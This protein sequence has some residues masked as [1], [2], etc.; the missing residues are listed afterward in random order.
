MTDS[1]TYAWIL[2]SVPESGGRLQD[3]IAMADGINH[4][5]PTHHELQRSLGWLKSRG[6]VLKQG[7]TFLLT[8]RGADLLARARSTN[9]TMMQTWDRVTAELTSLGGEEAPPDDVTVEEE[10]SA[11]DAYRKDFWKRY[12]SLRDGDA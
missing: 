2:L 4:A 8:E 9:Q 7:R 6:F 1:Q 5:I 11:Y 12:R 3:L 10:K